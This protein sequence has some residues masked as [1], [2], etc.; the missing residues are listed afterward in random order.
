MWI[1]LSSQGANL[2]RRTA[3]QTGVNREPVSAAPWLDQ[4]WPLDGTPFSGIT[5]L[6]LRPKPWT[7]KNALPSPVQP[8]CFY[9]WLLDVHS[10]RF[11]WNFLVKM[12]IIYPGKGAHLNR[13]YHKSQCFL[14]ILSW[15]KHLM[16]H[17]FPCTR[18][19]LFLQRTQGPP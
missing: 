2:R 1:G 5:F 12:W 16:A 6:L 13:Y 18:R 9:F 4:L 10:W 11:P 7:S 19:E 15:E 3:S 14:N 17:E 8:G